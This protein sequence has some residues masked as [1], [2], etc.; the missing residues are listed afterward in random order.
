MRRSGLAVLLEIAAHAC[1]VGDPDAAVEALS[2]LTHCVAPPASAPAALAATLEPG[3]RAA[4]EAVRSA[5]GIRTLLSI[6]LRSA[7][8]LPPAG[9]DAARAAACRALLGL[10]RDPFIAHT[11]QALHLARKLS[12]AVREHAGSVGAR[13]AAAAGTRTRAGPAAE[14]ASASST[15]AGAA[16]DFHRAAMELIAVAASGRGDVTAVAEAAAPPLHR[17]ERT[18]I[19]AAT[20]V[21]YQQTQLLQLIHE[22][23]SAAGLGGAAAAL[24]AEARL[25]LPPPA[26]AT[27]AALAAPLPS[28]SHTFARF[29]S[30]R[31]PR[32]AAEPPETAAA[33]LHSPRISLSLA[34]DASRRRSSVPLAADKIPG[35]PRGMKR[36]APASSPPSPPRQRQHCTPSR[37]PPG[38]VSPP[39]RSTTAP[40]PPLFSGCSP[41]AAAPL[42]SLASPPLSRVAASGTPFVAATLPPWQRA[43]LGFSDHWNGG[44]VRSRLDTIIT[45]SL[46]H[47][48]ALCAAPIAA[49]P[50]FSLREPHACAPPTRPLD[51]PAGVAARI[52]ASE[53]AGRWGGAGGARAMRAFV[54][55]KFRP[56]RTLR[57]LDGM[58][59]TCATWDSA[60]CER[61]LGGSADGLLHVWDASSGVCVGVQPSGHV[62]GSGSVT[63]LDAVAGSPLFASSSRAEVRLWSAEALRPDPLA[64][65]D[66]VRAGRLSGSATRLAA[67]C[68]PSRAACIFDCS[69]KALLHTLHDGVGPA[70]ARASA[71]ADVAW[72]ADE[73]SL[74]WGGAL[75]DA[76][77][78]APLVHRFDQVS[79]AAGA[80]VFHPNGLA[81]VLGTEMWDLRTLRLI[82]SMPQ[83]AGTDIRFGCNGKVGYSWLQSAGRED[84]RPSR[85]PLRT[86]FSTFDS[87]TFDWSDFGTHDTERTI[88]GLSLEASDRM[89][90]VVERGDAAD[91]SAVDACVRLYEVRW[92]RR[93]LTSY[94]RLCLTCILLSP[95]H[96]RLGAPA[97][98]T[99]TPVT[100]TMTA[101]QVAVTSRLRMMRPP[102]PPLRCA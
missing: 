82:R 55:S 76:R 3:L 38:I 65:W 60:A 15:G 83:L 22:H 99:R 48:H 17:L 32:A 59:I 86:A 16:A 80:S 70:G 21:R 96:A 74:L 41:S 6:L 4:R 102:R 42:P 19:A 34:K 8:S 66:G 88:L 94:L 1:N 85:H 9:A 81:A 77:A 61:V 20:P 11:L 37:K 25:F 69:T 45:A 10:A 56:V 12:D 52:A 35:Q 68:V 87:S 62:G 23:L 18:A 24:A 30:W 47:E 57:S 33:V 7:R 54:F 97:R 13:R 50:P 90:A 91:A 53:R 89:I 93:V 46:R 43:E 72:S 51:A 101:P 58:P 44:G 2:V 75:W 71:W 79:E 14:S 84:G 92:P 31:A 98:A 36:G 29:R 39:P 28:S 63:T 26:N 73:R 64:S 67:A 40:P 95:A 27:H 100:W 49:V 78:G 5:A